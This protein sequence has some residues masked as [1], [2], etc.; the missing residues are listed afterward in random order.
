MIAHK[1]NPEA[2]AM[3]ER[4][5]QGLIEMYESG[6]LVQVLGTQAG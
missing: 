6:E 4:L 1:S 3:L 2:I 5:D